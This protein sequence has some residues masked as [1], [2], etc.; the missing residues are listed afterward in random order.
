[1]NRR[2]WVPRFTP[3]EPVIAGSGLVRV[4]D[5]IAGLVVRVNQAMLAEKVRVVV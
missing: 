4:Y 2:V 5:P 3:V 1:M